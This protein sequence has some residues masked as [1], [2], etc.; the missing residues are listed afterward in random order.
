MN[1][2]LK[3]TITKIIADIEND[4]F[5]NEQNVCSGIVYP[6]LDELGW[7]SKNKKE[8]FEQFPIK[9][10]NGTTIKLDIALL[11]ENNKSQDKPLVFM[12][13]KAINKLKKDDGEKQLA[14]YTNCMT[15]IISILTNG[16]IWYFYNN[17]EIGTFSNKLFLTLN[18]CKNN[19]DKVVNYFTL[20]LHKD[21]YSF[22]EPEKSK[23][24]EKIKEIKAK[25]NKLAEIKKYLKQHSE[26][27][28]FDDADW[29]EIKNCCCVVKSEKVVV[30][31]TS[32]IFSPL[33]T[34]I[35]N[36][37]EGSKPKNIIIDNKNY[38]VNSWQNV[39]IKF[40][41]FIKDDDKFNLEV[42][43]NDQKKIFGKKDGIITWKQL[44]LKIKINEKLKTRY[45]SFEGSFAHNIKN[46]K[47]NKL[48]IY[49]NMSS[50]NCIKCIV[51]IMKKFNMAEDFV[52]ISIN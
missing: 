2:N 52:K 28:N 34:N 35:A 45:K 17:F 19:I 41:N 26:N 13:L 8:V 49:T 5:K 39:F 36:M 11:D 44:Q 30:E 24:L 38:D 10:A 1:E 33:D 22:V 7:N 43:L 14:A 4:N 12:E 37:V 18:L 15:P 51:N 3:N 9:G 46:I 42:I 27:T 16:K 40:L 31:Q 21:N 29:K 25:E 50:K 23:C 20:F 6:I 48:F 47:S 32:N